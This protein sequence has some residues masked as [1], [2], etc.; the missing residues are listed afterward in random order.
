MMPQDI[1]N[2]YI[3]CRSGSKIDNNIIIF[4]SIV[5]ELANLSEPTCFINLISINLFRLS[6]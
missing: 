4:L 6:F 2:Y 3:K 5:V 1:F